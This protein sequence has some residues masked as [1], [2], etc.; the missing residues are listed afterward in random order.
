M[1]VSTWAVL[2][3]FAAAG[4]LYV[5]VRVVRAVRLRRAERAWAESIARK[6]MQRQAE[7]A[8]SKHADATDSA[9]DRS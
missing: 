9:E 4:L 5:A 1:N 8:W 7:I 6:V 3:V 2:A